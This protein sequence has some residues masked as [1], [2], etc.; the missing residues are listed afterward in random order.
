[1]TKVTLALL[2]IAAACDKK[3]AGDPDPKGGTATPSIDTA[4]SPDSLPDDAAVA[5][6]S[7][8][9]TSEPPDA[10]VDPLEELSKRYESCVRADDRC[11]WKL[12]TDVNYDVGFL[13]VTKDQI[14]AVLRLG[15]ITLGHTVAV[16]ANGEFASP[17]SFDRTRG[18]AQSGFPRKVRLLA[19]ADAAEPA[20]LAAFAKLH[21]KAKPVGASGEY[22]AGIDRKE[23]VVRR[24]ENGAAV[25]LWT[26]E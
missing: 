17:K 26:F 1:M 18:T 5:A 3:P 22:V 6:E 9:A 23:L 11:G 20:N 15:G 25:E 24:F 13:L 2:V 12:R 8:D 14:F 7:P 21:K 10:A 19:K 16:K 4:P